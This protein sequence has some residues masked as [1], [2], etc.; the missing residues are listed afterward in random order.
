MVQIAAAAVV[1]PQDVGLAVAVEVVRMCRRFDGDVDQL[2]RAVGGRDRHQIVQRAA[3][4]S[5]WTAA[6]LSFSV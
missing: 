5:A 4:L 3:A 6:L 2:G 1:L